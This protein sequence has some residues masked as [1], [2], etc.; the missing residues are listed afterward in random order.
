M[1]Q[2]TLVEMQIEDGRKL[3]DRLTEEGVPVTA[4]FWAKESESGQWFL[5]LATP[6]VGEDGATK[7]AYRRMN[8]V[9]RRMP[10]PFWI[11]PLEV[12]LIGTADPITQDVL[13]VHERAGKSRVWPVRWGGTRLG[14]LSVDGAYFY[15]LPAGTSG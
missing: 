5:Y 2:G 10:A 14:D 7:P 9:F 12:K 13:A 1:D 3:I 11:D 6:L 15:P 4:A 8:A